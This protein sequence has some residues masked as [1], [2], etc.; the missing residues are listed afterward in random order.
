MLTLVPY[1]QKHRDTSVYNP[2]RMFDELEKSFFGSSD[3]AEF[4][5]DIR[6]EGDHYLMEADLPGFRKED[7]HVDLDNNT[8]TIQATRHSSYEEPDK[9]GGYV[10]CERSY[11]SYARSFGMDGIRTEGIKASYTDGV[12]RLTLPKVSAEAPQTRRLEIE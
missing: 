5:T 11:G 8:L 7:I 1:S 4:K 3:I 9:K 2:F 6:D 10:R 12:L